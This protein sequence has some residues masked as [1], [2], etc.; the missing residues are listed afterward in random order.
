MKF[1]P[2]TWARPLQ[3]VAGLSALLLLY[4]VLSGI[5]GIAWARHVANKALKGIAR[6]IS[7]Y[8]EIDKKAEL[9][10]QA[11]EALARQASELQKQA[12][13][14]RASRVKDREELLV[15]RKRE[16]ETNATLKRLL[17]EDANRPRITNLDAAA[18]AMNKALTK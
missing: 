10:N 4:M 9:N 11:V 6:T 2:L 18:A 8:D 17:I 13:A 5:G 1:N 16:A 7:D 12:D 3:I 14:E 15:I